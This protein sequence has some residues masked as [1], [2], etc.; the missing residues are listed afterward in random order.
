[1]GITSN[2]VPTFAT[3]DGGRVHYGVGYNGHGVA[4]SHT[5]GKILRDKVLGRDSDL[6]RL[7]FVDSPTAL[8]PPE[9]F[10]WAGAEISRRAMLRQ[11][12]QMDEGRLV[13]EMD[14]LILRVLNRL[15]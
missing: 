14:P 10:R 7:C 12:A 4:P 1:M 15:S 5:G 11:D 13:G 6:T 8:F 9:P 3:T 2:F